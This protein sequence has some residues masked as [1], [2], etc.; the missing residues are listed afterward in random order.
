MMNMSEKTCRPSVELQKA[1]GQPR[2]FKLGSGLPP[3]RPE[4]ERG[5]AEGEPG[6]DGSRASPKKVEPEN[7][8]SRYKQVIEF[9]IRFLSVLQ[10]R[11]HKKNVFDDFHGA[12]IPHVKK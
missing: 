7:A 3:H 9:L 2:S 4:G 6:L 5:E 10:S 1:A 12:N 11:T 8:H